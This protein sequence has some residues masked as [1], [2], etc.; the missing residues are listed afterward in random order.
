MKNLQTLSITNYIPSD[1]SN[2]KNLTRLKILRINNPQIFETCGRF[3]DSLQSLKLTNNNIKDLAVI[4]RLIGPNNNR[5]KYLS[6][7]DNPIDWNLYV[8]ISLDLQIE[9]S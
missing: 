5:L 8:Q 7:S 4:D 3:P 1:V 9:I 2:W 6:F